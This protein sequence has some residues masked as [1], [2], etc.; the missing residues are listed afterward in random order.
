M[1]EVIGWDLEQ[2]AR[3]SFVE[4]SGGDVAR[5]VHGRPMYSENPKV[6]GDWTP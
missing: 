2:D 3:L 6:K 1:N 4:C 5:T